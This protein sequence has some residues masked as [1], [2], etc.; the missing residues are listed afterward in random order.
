MTQREIDAIRKSAQGEQCTL[1]IAGICNYDSSTTV[2]AHL[3]D[4]TG[5]MGLKAGGELSG[6]YACS[7]CHDAIDGRK[8]RDWEPGDQ[9]FYMRRAHCRT[10]ARMFE[11]GILRVAA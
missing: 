2:Y 10:L 7:A 8:W 5:G 4:G 11:L 6:C 9:A 3:P 1:N